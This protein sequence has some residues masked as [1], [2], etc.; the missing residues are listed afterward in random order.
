MTSGAT[1]MPMMSM[2]VARVLIDV[3]AE[4]GVPRSTFMRAAKLDPAC[5]SAVDARLPRSKLFELF[6]LALEL[7]G[8]P[9]FGLH[10]QER[11]TSSALSPIAALV[12]HSATLREA[13]DSIREFRS[14]LGDMP[15]SQVHEEG[16]SVTIRCAS[17]ADESLAVRRYT[18]EVALVG[19]FHLIR[20]VHA[21]ARIDCV[22]FEY[23]APDYHHEYTRIFEGLARFEQPFTGIRF[24]RELMAAAAPH[25]DAE[26]HEALR[27]F[28][29]RRAMHL[30]GR[31]P[32][33]VRV[34]DVLVWQ[35]PPR[36]MT[37]ASVARKLGMSVRSLRRCLTAEG[38]AYRD[39]MNEALASIAKACLRDECRTILETALE[40]GFA[41][42]TSFHRAF[43]R[44]TGLTPLDYPKQQ[45][46]DADD[47]GGETILDQG[48]ADERSKRVGP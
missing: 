40:L 26:L 42:N 20:R 39:V 3:V 35:R 31:S 1:P 22:A 9:A 46:I 11:L 27:V 5:L 43:K 44:W 19:L 14:L 12:N 8:D 18:A 15:S 13:M 4:A 28:A 29:A 24:G 48:N 33:A 7:T 6:E 34:R 30:N 38:K 21:K 47:A 32:Y 25:P 2:R 10:S 45:A 36:D 16:G 17:L 23:G 37:M 41:D